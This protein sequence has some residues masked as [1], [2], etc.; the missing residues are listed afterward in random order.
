[1]VED[2][3]SEMLQPSSN[4]FSAVRLE[5]VEVEHNFISLWAALVVVVA[6]VG[7]VAPLVEDLVVLAVV[8]SIVLLVFHSLLTF[9]TGHGRQQQQQRQRQPEPEPEEELYKGDDDIEL[10]TGSNFNT[11][12]LADKDNVWLVQFYSPSCKRIPL[13]CNCL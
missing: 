13:I 2:S 6:L 10:L 4:N 3:I 8:V 7:V 1:V 11:K 5:E 12:V 9:N